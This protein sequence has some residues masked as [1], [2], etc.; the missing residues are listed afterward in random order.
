MPG[1]NNTKAIKSVYL[2]M[3]V[4][5]K[6]IQALLGLGFGPIAAS[7]SFRTSVMRIEVE[8]PKP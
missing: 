7:S 8:N 1:L 6:R 4:L 5:C 3:A 2:G